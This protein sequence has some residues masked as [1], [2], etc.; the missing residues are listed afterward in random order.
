MTM[1]PSQF[2]GCIVTYAAVAMCCCW[3]RGT[4]HRYVGF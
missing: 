4:T 1:K 3:W 2:H